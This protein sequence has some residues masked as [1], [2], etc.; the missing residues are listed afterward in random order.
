M[1]S[2]N[3]LPLVLEPNPLLHQVSHLVTDINEEIRDFAQK[4]IATMQYHNGLGLAAVQVGVL[5]RIIAIDITN[6]GQVEDDYLRLNE[7]PMILINPEIVEHSK[8]TKV[9]QEGCLSFGHI[10]PEIARPNKIKVKYWDLNGVENLLEASDN[11]I[12]SCIQHEIDHT[13]GIVFVDRLSKLKKE[14]MIKKYLKWRK[15]QQH[16]L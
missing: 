9:Y 13:N 10:Y 12:S 6:K 8:D 1:G 11:I 15:M 16:N 2:N 7:G 4:L 3:I 14:F 5:K